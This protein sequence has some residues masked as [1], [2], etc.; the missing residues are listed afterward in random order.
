M[1]GAGARQIAHD[2]V[3]EGYEVGSDGEVSPI[4]VDGTGQEGDAASVQGS[5]Q[6]IGCPVVQE[7][8]NGRYW[9]TY[10]GGRRKSVSWTQ[11]GQLEASRDV[12]KY[13]RDWHE[14]ATGE[15]WPLPELA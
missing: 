6:K 11:R 12:L 13:L 3:Q 4:S 15:C 2:S 14:E 7:D 5:S 1:A 8:R 9:V 10:A